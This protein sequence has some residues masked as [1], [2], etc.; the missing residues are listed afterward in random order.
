M[1]ITSYNNS[2]KYPETIYIDEAQPLVINSNETYARKMV[3]KYIL[4]SNGEF[5]KEWK[6]KWGQ[7]HREDGP[8]VVCADGFIAYY[9]NEQYHREDGPAIITPSGKHRYFIHGVEYPNLDA[10]KKEVISK[11]Y[12]PMK[13][14]SELEI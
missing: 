1:K 9:F 10:H 13:R 7:L 12:D 14:F 3:G 5:R 8:A 11:L 6:N 4:F 2:S